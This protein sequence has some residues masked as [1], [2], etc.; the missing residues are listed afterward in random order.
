MLMDGL[1]VLLRV[2][3]R[4]AIGRAA[5][6]DGTI[7]FLNEVA[8]ERGFQVVG[9]ATFASRYLNGDTSGSLTA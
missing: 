2:L 3:T 6:H 8:Y 4:A 5:F 1:P 7:Y 9:V